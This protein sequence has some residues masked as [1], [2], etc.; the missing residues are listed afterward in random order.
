MLEYFP[1]VPQ[2]QQRSDARGDASLPF[3]KAPSG[4]HSGDEEPP[5]LCPTEH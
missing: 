2:A 5:T 4:V 1:A 3:P